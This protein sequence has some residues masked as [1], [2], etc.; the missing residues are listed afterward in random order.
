M[1]FTEKKGDLFSIP[2]EYYLVHCISSDF[3]LGAGIAKTFDEKYD[4]RYKLMQTYKGH[5]KTHDNKSYIGKALMIDNVFNL[6]TK[7]RYW[8]KPVY[9]S[10]YNTLIDMKN[11]CIAH[12][13]TKLAMPRIGCGLDRLDWDRVSEMIKYVFADTDTDVIVYT[14]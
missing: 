14:L 5:P 1:T 12:G 3:A 11:Q 8:H 10:L 6:V 9:K 4:M 2:S 7:E 13:I